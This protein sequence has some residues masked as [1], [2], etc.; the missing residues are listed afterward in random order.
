M[1]FKELLSLIVV[2]IVLMGE[3]LMAEEYKD[4]DVPILFTHGDCDT[5]TSPVASR[6]FA[7]KI[8]SKDK[9]YLSFS[10][11]FHELHN[12]IAEDRAKVIKSYCD[13]IKT[14]LKSK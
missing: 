10:G 6:A 9:T 4:I 14:Q 11:C 13:W 7:N 12:E 3:E 5:Q 8:P 2:T 1:Y